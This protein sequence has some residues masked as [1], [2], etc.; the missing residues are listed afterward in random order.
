MTLVL[1]HSHFKPSPWGDGG[2]KRTAQ[3]S[4][5]LSENGLSEIWYEPDVTGIFKKKF[6]A[7]EG[8]QLLKKHKIQAS[9]TKSALTQLGFNYYKRLK[10][11]E[12]YAPNHQVF[13]WESSRQQNFLMSY[14]ATDAGI[15]VIGL[16]HNLESLVPGQKSDFT[17]KEA[18]DWFDEELSSLRQC[19]HIFTISREEQYILKLFG[20]QASYLPYFPPKPVVCFLETIRE[21]RKETQKSGKILMLGTAGNRPTEEGMMDR[22]QFFHEQVSDPNL[23]LFVAGYLT[24]RLKP[25]IPDNP[26]IHLLG[27]LTNEELNRELSECS[28]AWIHQPLGTGA[29]TKITELMI[30]GVPMLLNAESAR[31]YFN[32]PGLMVYENDKQCLNLLKGPYLI[33]E[34]P[35]KPID[36]EQQFV[37]I[38]RN[39]AGK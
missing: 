23:Q 22:I 25:M 31:N 4:E 33:P 9:F 39:Q 35:E 24:E 30:A 18:P 32:R 12:F 36:F 17:M 3:I 1:R 26:A 28:L 29:L 15:K 14:A 20:I 11:M 21:K 37:E 16:P 7:L 10:T 38:V 34:P 27:T 13:L 8:I 5:I 6:A 19:S 2:C